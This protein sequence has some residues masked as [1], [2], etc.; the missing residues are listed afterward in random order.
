VPS[1]LAVR[2]DALRALHHT[3]RPLV[4]A[5]AW[6]A[7]SARLVVA[8]GFPVV[9]TS[10][11]ALVT[12]LGYEDGSKADADIVFAA[13]LRIALAVDV[14]VTADIEDGYGLGADELAECLLDA[15]AVGCNLEDSDHRSSDEL[16]VPAERF[17]ERV[18]ALKAAGRDRGVDLV[19]NAR[20][21]VHLRQAGPPETRLDEALRRSR[22][23]LE[24]GADCVYPITVSDEETARAL[25]AGT[26]GPLNLLA[27]PDPADVARLASYGAARISVGSGL[28]RLADQS[29]SEVAELLAHAVAAP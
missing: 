8:A 18:A 23:Y 13:L 9:A 24:A 16:L 1:E 29:I 22:L 21:D 25:V 26:P 6:D 11:G 2:A 10:S 27:R 19:V 15:G 3:G 12:S 7:R 5:N 17:A 14:P 28:A 4:L 20:V